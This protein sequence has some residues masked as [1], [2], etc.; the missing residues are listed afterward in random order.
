MRVLVTGAAGFIKSLS[1]F[2]NKKIKSIIG[3]DN[4]EDGT[5]KNLKQ[6]TNSPKFKFY[7]LDLCNLKDR[8]VIQKD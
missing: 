5:L 3:I 6:S 2:I 1:R 8:K 4:L 7:K